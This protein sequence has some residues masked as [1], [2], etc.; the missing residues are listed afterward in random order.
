MITSSLLLETAK[1]F[2]TDSDEVVVRESIK[3]AYYYVYHTTLELLER[4]DIHSNY[5][6]GGVHEHL[7]QR[8]RTIHEKDGRKLADIFKRLKERRVDA[9]YHL[10]K[11]MSN[12]LAR[13]HLSECEK[14]ITFLNSTI[15]KYIT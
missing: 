5:S 3:L 14:Y 7:M 2:A 1:R 13:Q 4:H 6:Q 10:G 8:L 12:L 9:C 15:T 11:N